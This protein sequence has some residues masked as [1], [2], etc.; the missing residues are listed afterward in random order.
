MMKSKNA[1]RTIKL[2][3]MAIALSSAFAANAA[4]REI[5]EITSRLITPTSQ[6]GFGV[7]YL[8][9]ENMRFGQY[10]G[11]KQPGWLMNLN[12]DIVRRE[13]ETGTWWY[14]KAHDLG[15]DSRDVRVEHTRQGAWTYYLEYAELTRH[16]QYDVTTGLTGVGT[17]DLTINGTSLRTINPSTRRESIAVGGGFVLPAGWDVNVR[18]KSEEKQGTRLFGRGTPGAQQWLAD[19]IDFTMQQVDVTLGF[20]GEKFQM[21]TGYYGSFFMNE[22]R[23]LNITDPAGDPTNSRNIASF[24]PLG[25]PPDNYAHQFYVTGGYNF[26]PTTRATFKVSKARSTQEDRFFLETAPGVTTDSLEGE[27]ET[28]FLQAGITARPN[29]KLSLLANV[30]QMDRDDQT[31]IQQFFVTGGRTYDG[32]NEPRSVKS[33]FGLAEATYRLGGGYSVTAGLDYEARERNT[34]A[35]RV[36]SF[37]EETREHGYRLALKRMMSATLNGSIAFQRAIRGGDDF[38]TNV[39]ADGSDGSNVL[40]PI[41]LADRERDKL[42]LTASWTPT[43]DFSLQGLIEFSEDSYGGRLLG[44]REGN[45]SVISLDAAYA[46]NDFW[47]TTAWALRNDTRI[48][49]AARTGSNDWQSHTRYRDVAAGVGIKGTVSE[50]LKIGFDFSES[51]SDGQFLFASADTAAE[52]LPDVGYSMRTTKFFGEYRM[53]PDLA[54]R[55]DVVHERWETDDWQWRDYVYS[56]GTTITQDSSQDALF[57]GLMAVVTWR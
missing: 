56:D 13:A 40:A 42:K 27:V 17:N 25:L 26:T 31:P 32:R 37:R 6:V 8:F 35:L 51:Q 12:A 1:R 23:A 57:V 21:Q 22:Y 53:K 16:S 44:A 54:L 2:S 47:Q 38:E 5:D 34:S 3:A 15:H 11:L 9:G 10:T 30:R 50:K 20:T 46:I 18:F 43:R 24:S 4:M 45:A 39:L 28:T 29:S 14:V 55:L 36:V 19:P 52:S 33:T 7:G 41:H 49:Q 48:D